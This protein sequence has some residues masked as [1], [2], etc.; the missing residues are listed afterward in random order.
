MKKIVIALC[1]VVIF[2]L[3][4]LLA[5]VVSLVTAPNQ[6]VQQPAATLTTD[7]QADMAAEIASLEALVQ[8]LIL[9]GADTTSETQ[10]LQ[11]VAIDIAL[12]HIGYGTFTSVFLFTEDGQSVF[13]V[14]IRHEAMRYMVY[15]NATNGSVIRMESFVAD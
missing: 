9:G 1:G 10:I 14:E 6:V 8:E 13:E 5:L 12:G 3:G 2:A 15:V 11:Q 7:A 4:A